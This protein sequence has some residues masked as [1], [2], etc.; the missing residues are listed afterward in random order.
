MIK[1]LKC[2]RKKYTTCQNGWVMKA[3]V[4]ILRKGNV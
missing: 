2:L 1:I 4:E 3:E